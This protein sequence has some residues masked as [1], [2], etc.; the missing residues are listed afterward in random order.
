[1]C[2]GRKAPA[3][4]LRASNPGGQ[5]PRGKPGQRRPREQGK[6]RVKDG[7]VN[8]VKCPRRSGV[9]LTTTKQNG[10]AWEKGAPAMW[11]SNLIAGP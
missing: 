4:E 9:S 1:M 6:G 11:H 10:K 2:A 7:G 3:A 8:P 5:E